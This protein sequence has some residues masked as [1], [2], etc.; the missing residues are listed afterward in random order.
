MQNKLTDNGFV[1][2]T[3]QLTFGT[4]RYIQTNIRSFYSINWEDDEYL[5][6]LVDCWDFDYQLREKEIIIVDDTSDKKRLFLALK[7]GNDK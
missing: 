6:Q 5:N 3:E 2:H 1:Y 4:F 7:Y